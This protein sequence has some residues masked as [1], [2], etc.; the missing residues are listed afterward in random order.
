MIVVAGGLALYFVLLAVLS[1]TGAH[2]LYLSVVALRARRQVPP[3]PPPPAAWPRVLVQLP[4]YEEG[5]VGARAIAAASALRYPAEHREIQLLDDSRSEAW[6]ELALVAQRHGVVVLHRDDRAGFK[7]GAL[8]HGLRHSTAELVAIFDAD[9]V[10]PPEFLERAVSVLAAEPSVGLV[11]AR[12]GH[13]NRDASWL[14]RAQALLLD[15]HFTV[16]HAAR[17][18]QGHA[19]NFNGTAGVWRRQAIDDAGGWSA[20][21]LTE[22]LDLSYRAQLAGWRFVYLDALEVPAELPETWLGFRAQQARWAHG[23]IQTARKLLGRVWRAPDWSWGQKVEA[24]LHLA[25]NGAYLLLATLAVLLPPMVVLR[26][27]LGWRVPGGELLL[28]VLDLSMLG[29]GL[30]ALVL[31]YLAALHLRGRALDARA[32]VDVALALVVGAGLVVSNALEVVAALLGRGQREFVRT[33]KRGDAPAWA[34]R[35]RYRSPGAAGRARLEVAVAVLHACTIVYAVA[36]GTWGPVPFLAVFAAG[37][38]SMALATW[39][40]SRGAELQRR[41]AVVATSDAG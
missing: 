36:R 34:V 10:P 2:R 17:A 20:D 40:E 35:L 5:F 7:A 11:Q 39:R 25:A 22:D 13:L 4:T 41:H 6:R 14:T 32:L 16:E 30:G 37:L 21:T 1:V 29:V 24:T 38:G 23:G 27:Q 19:F 3:P 33:P 28:T 15:A 8:A 12:W 9:F 18:A 26:D 31:H